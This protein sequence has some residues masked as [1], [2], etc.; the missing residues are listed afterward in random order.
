MCI[1]L[2]IDGAL[3]VVMTCMHLKNDHNLMIF[4]SLFLRMW[5]SQYLCSIR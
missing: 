2:N 1:R 3:E 5:E 4:V